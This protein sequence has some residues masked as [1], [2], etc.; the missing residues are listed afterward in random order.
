MR[1]RGDDPTP[2]DARLGLSRKMS[3]IADDD[4]LVV[5]RAVAPPGRDVDEA[6]AYG[7]AYTGDRDLWLVLPDHSVTATMDRLPGSTSRCGSGPTGQKRSS[8][9]SSPSGRWTCWT[10]TGSMPCRRLSTCWAIRRPGWRPRRV[11]PGRLGRR[12]AH[13]PRLPRLEM[14]GSDVLGLVGPPRG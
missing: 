1:C 7:L 2:L 10:A 14:R 8:R 4:R 11:S 13:R 3:F 12:P 9:N 5:D 6:L